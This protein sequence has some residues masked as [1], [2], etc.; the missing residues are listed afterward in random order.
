VLITETVP[1]AKLVT[2][3][4][5]PSGLTAMEIGLALATIIRRCE[6]DP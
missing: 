6:I 3:A 5:L 1:S 4:T 2:Y